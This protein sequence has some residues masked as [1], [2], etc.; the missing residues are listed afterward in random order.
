MKIKTPSRLHFGIIDLSRK[1]R[2]EYGA[3]GVTLKDGYK[4]NIEEHS[5]ELNI[6]GN[7]RE[8]KII[9]DVFQRLKKD[10]DIS[11]GYE[12]EIEER[13]PEHVGLGSTTQLTLGTALGMLKISGKRVPTLKMAENLGR[14]RYSAIGTYGFENGG[15]ILE[16]G[17]IKSDEVS[18]LITRYSIPDDWK[19]LI[20]CPESSKG[21]DENEEKP[22]MEDL[23]VKKKYPEKISHNILMGIL[24][25][26]IEDDIEA[27][28]QHLTEIQKFVGKSFS[29]YQDGIYHPAVEDIVEDMVENTYGGGQSSWGPTAYGVVKEH[30][31]DDIKQ[32][33]NSD[34]DREIKIWIGE[35]NNDGVQIE[36]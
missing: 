2:R 21:Y 11:S 17:K 13:L 12:V 36:D 20:A 18:P 26:I 19:F 10:F 25:A 29:D 8:R 27:F 22:I 1:F 5:S 34:D 35:P 33:L 7:E 31:V 23:T 14:G 9:S 6:K 28:G 4:I 30:E 15:F 32:K 24:P 3:L 16:G